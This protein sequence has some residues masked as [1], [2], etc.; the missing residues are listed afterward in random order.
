MLRFRQFNFLL[1]IYIY[2]K[3]KCTCTFMKKSEEKCTFIS[4]LLK[5]NKA[6]CKQVSENECSY[7]HNTKTDVFFS[8]DLV[9]HTSSQ[10][11]WFTEE[12]ASVVV[13]SMQKLSSMSALLLPLFIF[14]SLLCCFLSSF[15]PSVSCTLLSILSKWWWNWKYVYECAQFHWFCDTMNKYLEVHICL[16]ILHCNSLK[17]LFSY[18]AN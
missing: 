6:F 2:E 16:T 15:F 18:K 10:G 11:V 4:V 13:A 5:A 7:L 3:W 14:A 9:V 17:G 8:P 1:N 12:V